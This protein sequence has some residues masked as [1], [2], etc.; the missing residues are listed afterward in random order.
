MIKYQTRLQMN[1][2]NLRWFEEHWIAAIGYFDKPIDVETSLGRPVLMAGQHR[3]FQRMSET[4]K[5]SLTERQHLHLCC[6]TAHILVF[7][8]RNLLVPCI[9]S[10]GLRE[11]PF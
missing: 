10:D 9:P 6:F 3:A 8:V 5:Q 4:T 2:T 1:R 7:V 11:L